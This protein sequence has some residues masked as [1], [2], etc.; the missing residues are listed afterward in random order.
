MKLIKL[1]ST[2]SFFVLL[3]FQSNLWAENFSLNK[4]RAQ[5]V[6]VQGQVYVKNSKGK[7]RQ[8]DS[9]PFVVNSD[10]TVLTSENSKAV[11][12]FD[13][14]VMSVLNE[15]SSLR[16]E[17]SG[18]LS[19][20]GGKVFYVFKKVF[21]K[22]K[23]KKVTTRFAT[24]GVRGTIFIVDVEKSSQQ[25]AL[26]EGELNIESPDDDYEFYKPASVVNDFSAYQ[27][28]VKQRQKKLN[29][30]FNDYKKNIAQKFIEY[31]K[32]FDLEANKVVSF[33]GKRVE[34]TDFNKDWQSLFDDFSRFSKDYI[35]AYKEL[36][37]SIQ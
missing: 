18:W 13:D 3:I 12:Q 2:L 24:I 31:K 35:G 21:G 26:Q 8:V 4:S 22:N 34:E 33:N 29:N 5:I 15:K 27:E 7:K 9:N 25:V 36:E 19:Q 11:L 32:S 16:I 30:E 17:K 14:G 6:K 28:Q 10:D 20:L 37:E 1:A 23:S